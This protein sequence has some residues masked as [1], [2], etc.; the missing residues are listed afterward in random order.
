[1]TLTGTNTYTGATAITAGTLALSTKGAISN[2]ASISIAAGATFDVSALTSTTYNLSASTS[3]SAAG[4]GIGSTAAD[5]NGAASGT[6]NLGAQPIS[7]TYTPSATNGDASDPALYVSQGTLQLNNNTITINNA[8]AHPLGAG[9]YTIIQQAAASI[10][11]TPNSV[12]T[13]TGSGLA[14]GATASVSVSGGS[15]NLVVV[16]SIPPT[17]VINSFS[18]VNGQLVLSGTNGSDNG[19]FVVL[20]STNAALPL[21][22]WT[23]LSTNT[24][25][26][27]GTFSVTNNFSGNQGFFIIG[28]PH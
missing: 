12:V 9:T 24:F 11:G 7:L 6:V 3:L 8:S 25:S 4:A 18:I 27:T 20:T 1:M 13:V 17:P 16:G 15:V 14:A 21:N 19:T 10:S 23:P 26:G 22:Q 2:S 5:I 28:I